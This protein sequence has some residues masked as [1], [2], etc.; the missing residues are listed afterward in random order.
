MA[1]T[2]EFSHLSEATI[3]FKSN[4]EPM[5]IR[6][7]LSLVDQDGNPAGYEFVSLPVQDLS[8]TKEL[9]HQ[10][11]EESGYVYDQITKNL[12]SLH[13]KIGDS[14]SEPIKAIVAHARKKTG[15]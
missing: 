11:D 6:V 13:N 2:I 4:G 5:F 12:V 8:F 14:L 3:E 1:K 10:L 9:H 7:R 15:Y